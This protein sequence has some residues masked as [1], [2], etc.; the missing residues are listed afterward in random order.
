MTL[1]SPDN[2]HPLVVLEGDHGDIWT[3][4]DQLVT[5]GE[6]MD[7]TATSL[8][9]IS[10]GETQISEAIDTLRE[11]AGEVHS[12]LT[13]A[14]LR[15]SGTGKVLRT[16]AHALSTGQTKMTP[17]VTQIEEK[18]AAVQAA[19]AEENDAQGKVNDYG[20]TWAWE[21]EPTD[22]QKDA[23]DTALSEASSAR[24]SLEGDLDDLWISYDQHFETWQDAYDTAV[25]G[26]ESAIEAA[27]N[28]DNWF[29]DALDMFVDL[30]GWVIVALVIVALFVAA[31]LAAVLMAVV[32]VLT[33][34]SLLSHLYLLTKGRATW[35]DIAFDVIGLIPFV[36]PAIAAIRGSSGVFNAASRFTALMN[37]SG[38]QAAV[39]IARSKLTHF[40]MHGVRGPAAQA[41]MRSRIAALLQPNAGPMRTA[42]ARILG[43]NAS[44]AELMILNNHIRT[45]VLGQ[46]PKMT[47]WLN[48]PTVLANLPGGGA[49]GVNVANF[50]VGLDQV[51]QK[52][53]PAYGDFREN[54]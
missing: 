4:G 6:T 38:A 44:T 43:G 9:K 50:I 28:N 11:A 47:S 54:Y 26:V 19:V 33:V 45:T 25:N 5:L 48:N 13:K 27:D 52:V 18:H 29:D 24:S 53:V 21:D 32:A 23:A 49:Q 41:A 39:G 12:D 20:R 35:T 37:S 2:N 51:G 30:L 3:R 15:Y 10:D 8:K 31:P 17:L 40:M 1:F 7:K 22:A 36:K 34:I 46:A 42:L 14:A 16:Y